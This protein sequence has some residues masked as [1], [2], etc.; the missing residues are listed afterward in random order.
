MKGIVK[1]LKGK[2]KGQIKS[3]Y[4][5]EHLY[6]DLNKYIYEYIMSKGKARIIFQLCIYVITVGAFIGK[7]TLYLTNF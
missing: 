1:V 4:R 6:Y 7:H 2:S 3:T 5:E